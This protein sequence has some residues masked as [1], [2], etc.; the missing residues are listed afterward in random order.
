MSGGRRIFFHFLLLCMFRDVC[1]VECYTGDFNTNLKMENVS[2]KVCAMFI[3]LPCNAELKGY[4]DY[5]EYDITKLDSLCAPTPS[6][7]S[8]YCNTDLC[9]RNFSA[10][11]EIWQA[12]PDYKPESSFST[13]LRK[14]SSELRKGIEGDENEGSDERT[15]EEVLVPVSGNP[16]IAEVHQKDS[17]EE[18][19]DYEIG[20][21]AK[22][23]GQIPECGSNFETR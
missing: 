7:F 11:L 13:C 16:E 3:F 23:L 18:E 8:C 14:A 22:N 10:F 17:E 5:A 12:S 15:T 4:F 1:A 21:K 9:N 2:E 20:R 19:E 6:I